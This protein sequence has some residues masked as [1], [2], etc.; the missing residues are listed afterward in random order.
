MSNTK[1]MT[2]DEFKKQKM[3]EMGLDDLDP[4]Q[5]DVHRLTPKSEGGQY[6]IGNMSVE[7]PKKHLIIHGNYRERTEEIEELKMY[8]DARRKLQKYYNSTANRIGAMER[9]V[10]RLHEDTHEWLLEQ[11][12]VVKKRLDS[13][14]RKVNRF[15]KNMEDPVAQSALGV[16]GVGGGTVASMLIYID[17]EKADY[18]SSLWSYTG[19]DKSYKDRY[20]KGESSGGNVNLRTDL[21]T[22]A[23]SQIRV[24][25]AYRDVYDREKEKKANSKKICQSGWRNTKGK[26]VTD[27]P[28]CEAPAGKIDGHAKRM[29]MKHFLADWWKVHRTFAGLETPQAYVL[30][31]LGH[32]SWIEP[33]E[34]GWVY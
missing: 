14:K 13:I 29:V 15:V 31:K 12:E 23:E 19:L 16:D 33:E 25:G 28:W 5:V 6:T 20:T 18:C 32:K 24:R 3:K 2:K 1:Q 27:K 21:Y 4:Y 9:N 10:D 8:V 26:M 30:E 34:R 11:K 17:I 7:K 22:F